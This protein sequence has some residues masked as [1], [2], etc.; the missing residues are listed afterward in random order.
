MRCRRW[1]KNRLCAFV[2][3]LE[4]PLL[5]HTSMIIHYNNHN[6]TGIAANTYTHTRK[7]IAYITRHA[8]YCLPKL[9]SV[10]HFSYSRFH[11]DA[12]HPQNEMWFFDFCFLG[13]IWSQLWTKCITCMHLLSKWHEFQYTNVHNKYLWQK[14]QR[15]SLL[16]MKH[17]R[18]KSPILI[19]LEKWLEIKNVQREKKFNKRIEVKMKWPKEKKITQTIYEYIWWPLNG[20]SEW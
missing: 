9:N 15:W 16:M 2:W 6:G 1:A 20:C 7:H 3:D 12:S 10:A 18:K 5:T 13:F 19:L 17:T 8:S 14:Q 4:L 11:D